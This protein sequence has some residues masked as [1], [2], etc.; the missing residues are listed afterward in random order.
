VAKVREEVGLGEDD[1]SDALWAERIVIKRSHNLN[2]ARK[3]ITD[4]GQDEAR[5][6]VAELRDKLGLPAESSS[7]DVWADRIVRG[8]HTLTDAFA[9]LVGRAVKE[10]R[11]KNGL[12][13]DQASDDIWVDRIARK[14]SH[15]IDD[16]REAIAKKAQNNT[17]TVT[18]QQVEDKSFSFE[19]DTILKKG[20]KNDAVTE[21]QEALKSWRSKALPRKGV[22]GEFNDET[23]DWTRRFQGAVGVSVNG[24]VNLQTRKAML[25]KLNS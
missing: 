5:S 1:A 19:Y 14:G 15:T 7:D 8:S 22:T 6:E 11:E 13:P 12:E 23:R 24:V 18:T 9:A 4:R 20:A 2:D 17:T 16:A 21:W 10:I 3:A 25:R